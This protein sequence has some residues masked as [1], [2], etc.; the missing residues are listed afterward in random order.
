MK[1]RFQRRCR[2]E[3]LAGAAAAL[4]ALVTAIWPEWIEL[5]TGLDP[6]R[7]SGEL[8]WLITGALALIAITCSLLARRDHRRLAQIEPSGP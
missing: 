8:E 5:L 4:L 7:G 1:D 2:I 6:D 3:A